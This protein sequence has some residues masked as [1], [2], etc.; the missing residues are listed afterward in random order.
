MRRALVLLAL[1][2][3]A[4]SALPAAAQRGA[5]YCN[6]TEI[7]SEQLSNGVRVTIV[8]DGELNWQLDFERLVSEGAIECQ[9]VYGEWGRG[10]N[11]MPTERF[12]RTPLRLMNAR[13]KLGSAFVPVS[14]YPVSHVE[15]S[16]PSWAVEGV[17]LEVDVVNYLS[18]FTGEGELFH[19]RYDF[20]FYPSDDRT[21]I[22]VAWTSD[23]FPPPP[24]PTTPARPPLRAED[25]RRSGGAEPV[26]REREAVRGGERHRGGDGLSGF[27]A[28][29]YGY[30]GQPQPAR[31]PPEA[32]DRGRGQGLRADRGPE[33]GW[34]LDRGR[35][36]GRD[37]E[38]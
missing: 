21:Q 20:W 23:R 2:V 33:A 22:I 8:A 1:L 29:R 6:V 11:C 14:K 36:G 27:D 5:A 37:R 25:H 38:L 30:A 15:I 13:S 12:T 31:P 18:W 7:K 28:R 34:V 3:L 4:L 24:P 10:I 19:P 9:V 35:G 32:G 16:I 26:G 17:G